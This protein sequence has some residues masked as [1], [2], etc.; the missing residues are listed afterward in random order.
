[1]TLPTT[2]PIWLVAL[3]FAAIAPWCVRA[4]SDGMERRLR[5]RT[6]AVLAHANAMRS[7]GMGNVDP[8]EI[9]EAQTGKHADTAHE[10]KPLE[11]LRE[12]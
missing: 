3:V 2:I 8:T 6:A 4:F 11:E 5:R 7:S 10:S 12:R 9:D 1:M